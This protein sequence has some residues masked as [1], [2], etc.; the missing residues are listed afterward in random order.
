MI[1]QDLDLFS[2]YPHPLVLHPGLWKSMPSFH[3]VCNAKSGVEAANSIDHTIGSLVA[4]TLAY[5]ANSPS[6]TFSGI[7]SLEPAVKLYQSL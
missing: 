6:P 1:N 5:Y 2:C 3:A 7:V 4:H